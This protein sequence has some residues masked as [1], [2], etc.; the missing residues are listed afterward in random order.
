[1]IRMLIADDHA[2]LRQGLKIIF[3]LSPDIELA[4][5]AVD[6]DGVLQHLRG[7]TN[8]DVLLMDMNMPGVSGISLIEHVKAYRKDLPILVFSMHNDQQLIVRT[9]KAGVAGFISKDKDPEILLDAIRKVAKGGKYIDPK[10]AEQMVLT[11]LLSEK[12]ELHDKLSN[13]ELEVFSLLVAG[14]RINEIADILVISNKT[15]SSHKKNLMEKMH[16]TCMA[17]LMRHS[18]QHKLFDDNV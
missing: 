12:S 4:G 14:K 6:G 11:G 9:L 10:F 15:A 13:R 3:E 1:M 8:F 7:T 17:D 16:F 5:E 2:V 18:I